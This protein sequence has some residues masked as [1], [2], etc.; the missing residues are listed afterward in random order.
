MRRCFYL[1]FS[2][3]SEYDL[4]RTKRTGHD[5]RFAA[6]TLLRIYLN[7]V[8]LMTNGPIRATSGAGGIFTVV[9]GDCTALLLMLDDSNPGLKMPLAQDMLLAVVGHDTGDLTGVALSLIHI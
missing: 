9:A 6:N 8:V 4:H 1:S 5:A 2:D 3:R 7:A